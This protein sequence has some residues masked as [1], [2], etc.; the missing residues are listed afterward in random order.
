MNFDSDTLQFFYHDGSL[1]KFQGVPVSLWWG[2]VTMT[3]V[4]YGDFFPLTHI[5]KLVGGIT[6]ILG[7]LVLSFPLSIMG[8]SYANASGRFRSR[9]ELKNEVELIKQG[10]KGK[11]KWY[12]E[13]DLTRRGVLLTAEMYKKAA[14]LQYCIEELQKDIDQVSQKYW[15]CLQIYEDQ[16]KQQYPD[17]L[18]DVW[19]YYVLG[20]PL[21]SKKVKV[22]GDRSINTATTMQSGN[23]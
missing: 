12:D 20:E 7:V 3:T 17:D 15:P 10:S 19:D 21:E 11:G 4:G 18:Y 8:M 5:G 1:S 23:E 6:A 22:I 2:V 14:R 9:V 13:P 16:H